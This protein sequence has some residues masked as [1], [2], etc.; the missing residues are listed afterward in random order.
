M[1]V[2]ALIRADE[3]LHVEQAVVI[4]AAPAA[5]VPC[6]LGEDDAL[7]TARHGYRRRQAGQPAADNCYIEFHKNIVIKEGCH[8]YIP[9]GNLTHCNFRA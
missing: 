5:G 6:R 8:D 7:A 4:G 2:G 3:A 1:E 9:F